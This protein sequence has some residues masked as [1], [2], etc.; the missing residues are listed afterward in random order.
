MSLPD[1]LVVFAAKCSKGSRLMTKSCSIIG[2]VV[3]RGSLRR[4]CQGRARD[5]H[6]AF[7]HERAQAPDFPAKAVPVLLLRRGRMM[8]LG[9]IDPLA[10]RKASALAFESR[11]G[12]AS[13]HS[14]AISRRGDTGCGNKHPAG[15]RLRRGG[16]PARGLVTASARFSG[17]FRPH[18]NYYDDF[19]CEDTCCR[20]SP[21]P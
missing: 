16:F 6:G 5:R 18:D 8:P 14:T 12:R 9:R 10:R 20:R 3:A 2:R 11:T 1:S 13:R 17:G 7:R 15:G 19:G 4:L 21:V